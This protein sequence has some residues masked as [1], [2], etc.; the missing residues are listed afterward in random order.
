MG[1]PWWTHLLPI[2]QFLLL[3]PL[4]WAIQ[5]VLWLWGASLGD[6]KW[7]SWFLEQLS[8]WRSWMLPAP[9][10]SLTAGGLGE[11]P[12]ARTCMTDSVSFTVVTRPWN[13]S[14][15]VLR[16]EDRMF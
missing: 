10:A 6:Y 2:P 13:G 16:L 11:T 5:R 14:G 15:E 12:E 1:W 3:V 4:V 8:A 9:H 7:P